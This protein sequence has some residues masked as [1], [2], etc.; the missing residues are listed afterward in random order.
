MKVV[1]VDHMIHAIW[2]AS[3]SQRTTEGFSRCLCS[4]FRVSILLIALRSPKQQNAQQLSS[5]RECK[6][7]P[8]NPQSSRAGC[9]ESPSSEFSLIRRVVWRWNAVH[10]ARRF[11]KKNVFDTVAVYPKTTHSGFGE[12]SI[13][14]FR[15]DIEDPPSVE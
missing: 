2:Q 7:R 15:R 3:S 5:S 4:L 14:S 9:I 13:V 11:R 1:A 6:S 12:C 8:G 10:E